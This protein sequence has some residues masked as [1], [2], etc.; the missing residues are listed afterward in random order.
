VAYPAKPLCACSALLFN[1]HFQHQLNARFSSLF[2]TTQWPN[3][4]GQLRK[5]RLKAMNKNQHHK[6]KSK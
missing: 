2:L 3:F 5:K 1:I 4:G 6:S